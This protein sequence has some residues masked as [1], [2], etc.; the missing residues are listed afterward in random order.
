MRT[1]LKLTSASLIFG[2]VACFGG[3]DAPATPPPSSPTV[4][5]PIVVPTT[6]AVITIPGSRIEITDASGN[7]GQTVPVQVMIFDAETGISGFII[8]VSVADPRVGRITNVEMPKLGIEEFSEVPATS[9]T[10]M[11]ADIQ[12]LLQGDIKE[13]WLATLDI[14]LLKEGTTELLVDVRQVDDDQGNIVQ[15]EVVFGT[16]TVN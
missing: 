15:S 11:A 12:E 3:S 2:A 7:V 13:A 5:A 1:F 10:I 14:E 6:P 4:A 8:V 16:L 9:I